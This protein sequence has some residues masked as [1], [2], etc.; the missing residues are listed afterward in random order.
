[1]KS[2]IGS[3][4]NGWGGG[5]KKEIDFNF[6]TKLTKSLYFVLSNKKF[7]YCNHFQMLFR[8]FLKNLYKWIGRTRTGTDRKQ[9]LNTATNDR[10]L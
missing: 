8:V 7:V 1:M 3:V 10:K 4:N 6:P 9:T 5:E 2:I